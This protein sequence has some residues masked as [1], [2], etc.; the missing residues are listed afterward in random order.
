MIGNAVD[1]VK[2]MV[3]GGSLLGK[4]AVAATGGEV[5]EGRRP[6]AQMHRSVNVLDEVLLRRAACRHTQWV[7]GDD[8]FLVLGVSVKRLP[9]MCGSQV[10]S[11]YI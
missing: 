4:E 1:W 6:I 7:T 8:K 11:P 9:R 3:L 10:I 5:D 2:D